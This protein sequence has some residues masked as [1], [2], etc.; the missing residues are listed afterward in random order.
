[1]FRLLAIQFLR[2][3]TCQVGLALILV[4]GLISIIMGRQFLE[5]RREM[6]EQTIN[7]QEE[8]IA[9]NIEFH[10][11]DLG[12]LLYYLKFS[13]IHEQNPLAALSI[14]QNDL[15]PSVLNFKI[16]TLEGQRYDTDLV[17]SLRLL[18]GNLDLS[19]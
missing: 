10:G 3:R 5:D 18:S 19:F 7:Q 11:D 13:L 15:N 12:L 9:R 8:H 2:T 1:M 4:L 14:G 6:V 16:L 17:N